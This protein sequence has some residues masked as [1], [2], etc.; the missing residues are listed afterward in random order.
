ML[1]LIGSTSAQDLL[2]GLEHSAKVGTTRKLDAV[3]LEGKLNPNDVRYEALDNAIK[4]AQNLK[5]VQLQHKI[6]LLDEAHLLPKK[7]RDEYKRQQKELQ[8]FRNEL[9]HRMV[10]DY[11]ESGSRISKAEILNIPTEFLHVSAARILKNIPEGQ[12]RKEFKSNWKASIVD[13]GARTSFGTML[14]MINLYGFDHELVKSFNKS[15][16]PYRD[17]FENVHTK[18]SGTISRQERN[19]FVYRIFQNSNLAL[20]RP[21]Q[22]KLNKIALMERNFNEKDSSLQTRKLALRKLEFEKLAFFNLL[23]SSG[24]NLSLNEPLSMEQIEQS[25][26]N[27][28]KKNSLEPETLVWPFDEP[29]EVLSPMNLPEKPYCLVRTIDSNALKAPANGKIVQIN[30]RRI[31]ILTAQ[32]WIMFEGAFKSLLS[33]NSKVSTTEILALNEAPYE[34]RVTLQNTAQEKSWKDICELR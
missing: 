29:T 31:I 34:V 4:D 1:T 8:E 26:F 3:K 7:R 23:I 30:H 11:S 22:I 28:F 12:Q 32:H 24:L 18:F 5:L 13:R 2:L 14:A 6:Q 27:W 20:D 16:G 19:D 33:K 21:L 9:A 25:I 15:L 10:E 17:S